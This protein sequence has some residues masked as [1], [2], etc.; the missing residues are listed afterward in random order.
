MAV[1]VFIAPRMPVHKLLLARVI[2]QLC[3]KQL[4]DAALVL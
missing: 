4:K 3:K 1:V 2:A